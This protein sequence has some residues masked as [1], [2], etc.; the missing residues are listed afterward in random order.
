M[1][2]SINKYSIVELKC[3][4]LVH[5]NAG[6]PDVPIVKPM[7]YKNLGSRVVLSAVSSKVSL[8]MHFRSGVNRGKLTTEVTPGG[9]A[10]GRPFVG[11]PSPAQ[12]S[13]RSQAY[14]QRFESLDLWV[15]ISLQG[16][17][18]S[19]LLTRGLVCPPPFRAI[20]SHRVPKM[21]WNP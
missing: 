16:S 20:L 7:P 21:R 12:A 8:R 1:I 5:E 17:G 13:D 2:L 4:V 6:R 11:T 19:C 3:Q 14:E 10:A 18:C 9:R 15:I